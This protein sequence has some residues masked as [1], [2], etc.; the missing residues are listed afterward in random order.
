MDKDELERLL[1]SVELTEEEENISIEDEMAEILN[2]RAEH[3]EG[4]A[5]EKP[6]TNTESAESVE[7]VA[8]TVFADGA[9]AVFDTEPA[10]SAETVADTEFTDRA[11]AVSD[12][13]A[14]QSREP[15]GNSAAG[16]INEYQY[17]E[18]KRFL[19]FSR[20]LVGLCLLP[21]I[22]I[23]III[24]IFSTQSLRS[25]I[26]KE[27]EKSLQIVAVSMDETY[28]NLYEGDYK[29]GMTGKITKGDTT[30]SGDI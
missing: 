24:T 25:G 20:K 30:I 3:M 15:V 10:G 9:E 5:G 7:A 21:M 1:A 6:V 8:D 12:M 22:F 26:E 28:T 27:I 2:M 16:N 11:E 29:K 17:Q 23:C 4:S 19:T 13:E 14:A 18:R